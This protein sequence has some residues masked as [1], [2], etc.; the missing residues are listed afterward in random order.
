MWFG[1]H[2]GV[3]FSSAAGLW[4]WVVI[5]LKPKGSYK[6]RLQ[7]TLVKPAPSLLTAYFS[8]YWLGYSD[9]IVHSLDWS[10]GA[11]FP[12]HFLFINFHVYSYTDSITTSPIIHKPLV[13]NS[14]LFK[15]YIF[16][17][18]SILSQHNCPGSLYIPQFHKNQ[19]QHAP[20]CFFIVLF[21]S[22]LRHTLAQKKRNPNCWTACMILRELAQNF[23]RS[24]PLS[25]QEP[26]SSIPGSLHLRKTNTHPIT[27][28]RNHGSNNGLDSKTQWR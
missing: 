22:I 24:S 18:L 12:C 27:R 26:N 10:K 28:M 25:I 17:I 23:P 13:N 5:M 19:F 14:E 6:G 16:K 8:F 21:P 7:L 4:C 3:V 15:T 2:T 11:S 20:H 1:K 9:A